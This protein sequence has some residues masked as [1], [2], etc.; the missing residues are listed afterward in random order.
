MIRRLMADKA[1]NNMV[2]ILRTHSEYISD[3]LLY[4]KTLMV[5]Y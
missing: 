5:I 3:I 2:R 1:D 4:F